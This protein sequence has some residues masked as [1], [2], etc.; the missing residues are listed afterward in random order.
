MARLKR[1]R[2]L[3]APRK[4]KSFFGLFSTTHDI[5]RISKSRVK[6]CGYSHEIS[7][8]SDGARPHITDGFI[9]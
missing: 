9:P 5:I 6:I 8:S 1:L 4:G 7:G 3:V 2:R